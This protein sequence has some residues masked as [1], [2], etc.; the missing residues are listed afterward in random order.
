MFVHF[1]RV[2]PGS[3][4]GPGFVCRLLYEI[5]EAKHPFGLHTALICHP[6][7]APFLTPSKHA[8]KS[9]SVYRFGLELTILKM[10]LL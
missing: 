7:G 2:A 6:D 5:C 8:L 4:M 9:H 1:V 3:W 10:C